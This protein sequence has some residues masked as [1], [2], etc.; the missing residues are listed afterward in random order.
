M[1]PPDGGLRRAGLSRR[2]DVALAPHGKTLYVHA[3]RTGVHWR[4]STP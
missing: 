3:V 2:A 4:L 1:E